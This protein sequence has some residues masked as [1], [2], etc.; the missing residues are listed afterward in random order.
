MANTLTQA[1]VELTPLDLLYRIVEL[2]PTPTGERYFAIIL[3]VEPSI[4][5][6]NTLVGSTHIGN[7]VRDVLPPGVDA[8]RSIELTK[9]TAIN[10][11]RCGDIWGMK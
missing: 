3:R 11:I 6:G 1:P 9:D 2:P 10:G 4:R 5:L 7:Y 8:I